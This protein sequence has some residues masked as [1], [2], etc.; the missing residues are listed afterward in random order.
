VGETTGVPAGGAPAEPTRPG[1]V[2]EVAF[3]YERHGAQRPI[4]N[5]GV[6]AGRALA[7]TVR[8]T[9]GE[10]DF[11]THVERTVATD[12]GVG[13]VFEADDPTTRASATLVLRVASLCGIA[14]A[15]LGEGGSGVLESVATRRAFPTDAGR[16]VRFVCVPRHTSWP[17]PAGIRFGVPARRVVR[18]GNSRSVGDLRE[19]I[20][21]HIAYYSRTRAEPYKWTYT[22]RPLGAGFTP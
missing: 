4:G 12:P 7:P 10:K 16:R 2:E 18:R 17:N 8:A 13:W 6:A 1:H 9:R 22:G 20:P 19:E 5:F 21:A 14:A 15:W 11:A 3:A